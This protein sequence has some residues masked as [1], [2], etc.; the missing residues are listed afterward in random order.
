MADPGNRRPQ[1]TVVFKTPPFDRSAIPPHRIFLPES[2]V[3]KKP[4]AGPR[5]C[6]RE[7]HHDV[8][9]PARPRP[10]AHQTGDDERAEFTVPIEPGARRKAPRTLEPSIR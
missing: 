10:A 9:Q 1:S 4:E 3:L 6:P 8:R 5:M 7:C 2:R